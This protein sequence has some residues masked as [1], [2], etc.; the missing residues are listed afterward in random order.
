MSNEDNRISEAGD[1]VIEE[2]VILTS[3]GYEV[4]I[5]P[6]AIVINEDTNLSTI[7]GKLLFSD[8]VGLSGIAPI[9]GQERLRLKIR[10]PSF[11]GE[12]VI[13]N[14]SDD[15]LAL[16]SVVQ[17]EYFDN[18]VEAVSVNFVTNDFIKNM[19][20]K[21][22]KK[23]EGSYSDIV[24]KILKQEIKT[25]KRDDQ[26]F[27]SETVGNKKV[28]IP[29]MRPFDFIQNIA[30]KDSISKATGAPGY[31]F[32]ETIRGYVFKSFSDIFASETITKFDPA[33]S[34]EE[35][36]IRTGP[37]TGTHDIIKGFQF[38]TDFEISQGN[39]IVLNH[40]SGVY[41]SKLLEYDILSKDYKEHDFDYFES[42]K[43]KEHL[44]QFPVFSKAKDENNK[45]ISEYPVRTFLHHKEKE[46]AA[47]L[48]KSFSQRIQMEQGLVTNILVR[49]N[50]SVSAGDIVEFDVPLPASLERDDTF[51][52]AEDGLDPFYKGRF[53]V[54]RIEHT[55]HLGESPKHSMLMTL[56]KDGSA[57]NIEIM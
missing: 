26:I 11:D 6:A 45:K 33:I 20:T 34:V 39:D 35:L 14:Y 53:F 47:W 27:I 7:S 56:I 2:L 54:K 4:S 36:V 37:G 29:D 55:F 49:G 22:K 42:F 46:P 50:T 38:V 28:V 40:A 1:F 24:K 43:P 8:G 52:A 12:D 3:T 17:K 51:V 44:D 41:G 48:Q 23:V 57:T 19:R 25:K 30:M 18:G 5:A 21:L 16:Q 13:I 32:F 10:T 31:V 15:P 9:I